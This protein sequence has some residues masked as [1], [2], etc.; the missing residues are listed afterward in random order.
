MKF[1]DIK[2]QGVSD[3]GNVWVIGTLVLDS[4]IEISDIFATN[5]KEELDATQV[6]KIKKVKISRFKGSDRFSLKLEF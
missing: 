2:K 1:C 4:G 3:K 6:Y 5:L